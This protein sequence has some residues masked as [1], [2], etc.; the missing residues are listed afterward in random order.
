MIF[1]LYVHFEYRRQG[2]AKKLLQ[3][4]INEIRETGYGGEIAVEADPREGSIDLDKLL[5]FYKSMGLKI[6]EGR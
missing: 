2:K 6:I 4:A 3:Y 5:L 1:N